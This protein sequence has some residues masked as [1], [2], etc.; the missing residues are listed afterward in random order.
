MNCFA[1]KFDFYSFFQGPLL[2]QTAP[3]SSFSETVKNC[4]RTALS[5]SLPLRGTAEHEQLDREQKKYFSVEGDMKRVH[6]KKT[7]QTS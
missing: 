7:K 1:K 4:P 2:I 3:G 5:V 6:K